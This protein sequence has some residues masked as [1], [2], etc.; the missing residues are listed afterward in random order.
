MVHSDLTEIMPT[1]EREQFSSHERR[2]LRRIELS[3]EL[4]ES[5]EVFP[6]EGFKDGAYEK[7]KEAVLLVEGDY[8]APVDV[9]IE[10]FKKVGIKVLSG[11]SVITIPKNKSVDTYGPSDS[12][13]GFYGEDLIYIKNFQITQFTD[14]RLSELIE[15][16]VE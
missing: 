14:P 10:R 2:V 12:E 3:H 13:R 16:S 8:A 9:L 1:N 7:L 6:F 15:L 4:C 5:G 11:P